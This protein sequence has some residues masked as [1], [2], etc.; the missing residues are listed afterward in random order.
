M[1]IKNKSVVDDD[2]SVLRLNEGD[3]TESVAVP[4]GKIIVPLK[5]WQAQRD[6][7]SQRAD[8]G[9]WLNSDERAEDLQDDLAKFAVIAVNFP[10]FADGRGYSIA[11]HL[12][13][14]LGYRGELRAIGDVLRDQLFYMQR[15]GFDAFAPRADKDI[16]EAL[17]GLS[18]FSL[19]YQASSDEGQPLFRR[20]Q[21][22]G[23][24]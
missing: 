2:W 13:T 9:V 18:D 20:V 17:K 22:G 23:A 5:V 14:R 19:S 12:R 15:A 6:K 16:H 3:T 8:L 21:R 24:A 4:S 7:L 1:I 10:K 11:Y